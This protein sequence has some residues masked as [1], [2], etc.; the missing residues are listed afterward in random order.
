M[1]IKFRWISIPTFITINSQLKRK[2]NENQLLE[3]I[4]SVAPRFTSG[5]TIQVFEIKGRTTF[6]LTCGAQ[7][8]PV[9]VYKWVSN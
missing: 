8:F 2:L 1:S 7:S 5:Q 3:P 6:S 9:P 4:G